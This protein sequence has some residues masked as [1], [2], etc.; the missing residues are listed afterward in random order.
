MKAAL[1]AALYL[2]C[3]PCA[4][5]QAPAAK[6]CSEPERRQFDFWIGEWDVTGLKTGQKAGENSI[7]AIHDGC[8]LRESWRGAKGSTGTSLNAFF[9]GQWHQTW[10]DNSGLLLRLDGG[11]RDGKMVLEGE[12]RARDGGRV[13]HRIS[14]EPRPDGSV[15]QHWETSRDGGRT[16]TTAFDGLYVRKP[17]P[18]TS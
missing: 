16:W 9:G 15:R 13:L 3:V 2:S 12:T 18:A 7:V 5:G 8:A 10:V 14:Y 4:F 11:L 6:P 1:V 17:G